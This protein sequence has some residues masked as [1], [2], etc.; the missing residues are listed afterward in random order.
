MA[1]SLENLE[2]HHFKY[3]G[4]R[5]P[6]QAHVHFFGA[7]AFSFGNGVK[8]QDADIMYIQWNGL[9]RALQNSISISKEEEKITAIKS[10]LE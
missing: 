2:Y 7:D 3:P 4:H 6:L 8:L 5:I 9:G 1:H 10:L